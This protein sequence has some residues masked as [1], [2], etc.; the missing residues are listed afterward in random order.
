MKS[1]TRILL[2]LYCALLLIGPRH[3]LAAVAVTTYHY[4]TLRTG[5]NSHEITLSDSAFPARFGV[6]GVTALDDQVDSQPLLVPGEYIAGGMHNVVY[7]A[8]ESNTVYGLDATSG[9]VL[10]HRNLGP[11]MPMPL[12]CTT[13]GPNVGINSTPVIDLSRGRLYVIAYVEAGSPSYQLHALNL[14]TLAD[15]VAPI[16]VKAT[17]TLTNGSTYTF[18]AR[19]QRQRSGLLELNGVIY[20]GFA[21]FC[22]FGAN[23]SRGWVLGWSAS[24][25]APLLKN[26]LT[27]SRATVRYHAID[28]NIT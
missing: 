15:A 28:Y 21:S 18:N 19:Y 6:L 23:V 8:T 5:W 22:D 24:N 9:A 27:D 25:L 14:L 4:D 3:T 26:E 20:A 10:V 1:P 13:N 12:G 17:H 7:V 11:P 2:V 16:T